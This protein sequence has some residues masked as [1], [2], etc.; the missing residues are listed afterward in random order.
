[1][2]VSSNQSVS[3]N[4][5][6]SR[7]KR[8][9]RHTVGVFVGAYPCGTIVLYD[10]LYGSESITQVYGILIS[11]LDKLK[12]RSTLKE[13]LYDDQCHLKKLAEDSKYAD[14]NEV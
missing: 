7:D 14:R 8:E 10:E 2:V 1:M 13:I 3:C 4:T 6:K 12:D 9:R 11:F 5:R